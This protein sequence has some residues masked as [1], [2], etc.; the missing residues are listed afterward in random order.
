MKEYFA[1]WGDSYVNP[2]KKIVPFEFFSEALC[3]S[4]EDRE[5]IAELDYGETYIVGAG[6]HFV[7]LFRKE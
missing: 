4:D 5:A 3:Y 2:G 7:A 1:S 6:H